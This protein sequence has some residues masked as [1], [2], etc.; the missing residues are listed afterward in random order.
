MKK[1]RTL[2]LGAHMSI[3]GGL[4]LAI[5]RAES[6]EC[7]AIQI[8]T[9]SN[10]QWHAKP[11]AQQDIDLF[12]KAWKESPLVK[13][14]VVHAS[15]LI[16]I[17]SA[18][19][20]LEKKSLHALD[21]EFK[22]CAA[23]G[24]P[25]L[26]LHP[27]SYTQ[28]DEQSCILQISKNID[29]LLE[30]NPDGMLLLETMAG[31]GSQVGY[32]FEQLAEIIKHSHH[33]KR[34]GVCIDTCHLFAAGYDFSSEKGYHDVWHQIDKVI[35]RE[36]IK[37]IHLND[38]HKDLGSHVDRHADIGKGKIGLKGFE[39]LLNDPHLFDIPKILETPRADLADYRR[40][41]DVLTDLLSKKTRELLTI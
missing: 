40:N 5:T 41:M 22:R 20:E 25:Y 32:T 35:G 36:K 1:E 18:N 13:S 15:Y 9:K 6:I 24:I 3:S 23:L 21:I 16:N 28:Q 10:R 38:S 19:K 27:G 14:I 7:T 4:H 12:T 30:N 8:F 31:Q 2:L 33:K 26:V 29:I 17:G 11:L 39:L 34:L 37:A